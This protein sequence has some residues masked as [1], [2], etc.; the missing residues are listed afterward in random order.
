MVFAYSGA[1]SNATK[2]EKIGLIEPPSNVVDFKLYPIQ[3][4]NGLTTKLHL[5][6]AL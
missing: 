4:S 5:R 1:V 2:T 3:N 6:V